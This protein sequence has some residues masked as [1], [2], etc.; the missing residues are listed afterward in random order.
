M[1]FKFENLIIWQ[2]AMEL[3]EDVNKL[4]DKFPK[5]R[6]TIFPLKFVELPIL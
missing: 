6:C 3:G 4:S 1:N 5:K 2:K